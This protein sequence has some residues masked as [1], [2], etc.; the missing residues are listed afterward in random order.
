[1]KIPRIR[2]ASTMAIVAW[3]RFAQSMRSIVMVSVAAIA[4]IA[5]I[6]GAA[7]ARVG[8]GRA[9]SQSIADWSPS[10]EDRARSPDQLAASA[11]PIAMAIIVASAAA[12]EN[13]GRTSRRHNSMIPRATAVIAR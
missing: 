13:A 8:S 10:R 5:T 4:Q 3:R 2:A 11:T 12:N 6:A 9:T 7:N 1:M